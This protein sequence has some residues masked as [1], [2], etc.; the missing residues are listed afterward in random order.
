MLRR[1]P[2]STLFPY[3]TLFRSPD[4]VI[5]P[6]AVTIPEPVSVPPDCVSDPMLAPLLPILSVPVEMLTAL[7]R[8]DSV[9]SEEHTAELQSRDNLVSRHVL[10]TK[11]LHPEKR[12]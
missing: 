10:D 7:P 3:T 2:L 1:P 8:F 9:R 6:L 12:S 11:N 5:A 4:H